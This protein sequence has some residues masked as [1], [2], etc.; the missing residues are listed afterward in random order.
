M[1][2]AEAITANPGL[3]SFDFRNIT[4]SFFP[5]GGDKA[6]DVGIKAI[7]DNAKIHT[8]LSSFNLCTFDYTKHIGVYNIAGQGL[9]YLT[10]TVKTNLQIK[11]FRISL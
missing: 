10:E 4:A 11:T 1:A 8:S 9:S 3:C 5:L 2:M 6:S 7:A